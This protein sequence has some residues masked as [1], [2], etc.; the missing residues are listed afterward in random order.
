MESAHGRCRNPGVLAKALGFLIAFLVVF[1]VLFGS[2][3]GSVR[4]AANRRWQEM[5]AWAE[6]AHAGLEARNWR[7]E[8]VWGETREGPAFEH[9]QRAFT[10][11][12]RLY[13]DHKA[14][15]RWSEGTL[16]EQERE[17]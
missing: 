2:I 9:Y 15:H 12:E 10:L 3:A 17:A 4:D 16:P 11:A 6:D 5:A 13:H 1:G 8:A 14:F 7:R